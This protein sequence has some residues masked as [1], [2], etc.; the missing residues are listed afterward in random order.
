MTLYINQGEIL[1]YRMDDAGQVMTVTGIARSAGPLT[2]TRLDGSK[3]TEFV[4]P[5]FIRGIDESTG[6]PYVAALADKKISSEHPPTLFDALGDRALDLKNDQGKVVGRSQNKIH[7]YSDG[8]VEVIFDVFD[9]AEQEAIRNG[10]K[11]GLSV[12]Y[13]CGTK[14]D[15]GEWN[16]IHYDAVQVPPWEVDHIALCRNPRNQEAIITKFDSADEVAVQI[17]EPVATKEGKQD[18]EQLYQ[19]EVNG[20]PFMVPLD[21]YLAI[22]AESDI[23]SDDYEEEGMPGIFDSESRM[24]KGP[25]CPGPGDCS[26]TGGKARYKNSKAGANRVAAEKEALGRLGV[27]AASGDKKKRLNELRNKMRTKKLREK[28][29]AK[30]KDIFGSSYGSS[31]EDV[32]RQMH[33]NAYGPSQSN[34]K[35]AKNVAMSAASRAAVEKPMGAKARKN[36]AEKA[37]AKR[38]KRD[39]L[40]SYLL[41]HFDAEDDTQLYPIAVNGQDFEVPADL[42]LALAQEQ[43][44]NEDYE[45]SE[46]KYSDIFD[47]EDEEL[48][49]ILMDAKKKKMMEE[50]DEEM[51]DEEEMMDS[52]EPTRS[53]SD[54][55]WMSDRI[56]SLESELSALQAKCDAQDKLLAKFDAIDLEEMISERVDAILETYNELRPYLPEDFKLDG[57]ASVVGM[58][59]DAIKELDSESDVSDETPEAVLDSVL[60]V[61]TRYHR[62]DSTEMQRQILNTPQVKA[63]GGWEGALKPKSMKPLTYGK[64][65]K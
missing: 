63:D 16:G 64:S 13:R 25:G 45:D 20:R 36:M 62:K 44:E 42:F 1:N 53:D 6:M 38:S 31:I 32:A 37:L 54:T 3:W 49:K 23:E 18:A 29:E 41:D 55:I 60:S 34:K 28:F 33:R 11:R 5:E 17:V 48:L 10:E 40:L 58:K 2:Y 56:D 59:L 30:A 57:N 24:D 35:A 47:S 46:M 22:K 43:I 7:V 12:G 14:N 19:I 15:A 39:S 50:E 61:L 52:S 65:K 26:K 4:S 8:K 27:G 9:S 51:E 21:L